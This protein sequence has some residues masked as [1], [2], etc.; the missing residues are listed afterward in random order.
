MYHSASYSPCQIGPLKRPHPRTHTLTN[1]HQAP[2]SPARAHNTH[3]LSPSLSFTLFFPPSLSLLSHIHARFL[4]REES[5]PEFLR[6]CICERSDSSLCKQR[7]SLCKQRTSLCKQR[8]G[9]VRIL[10]LYIYS[11]TLLCVNRE[12]LCVNRELL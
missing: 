4:N 9:A 11:A 10:C 6:A 5:L 2:F 12:L 1:T 3:I 8:R 7:T